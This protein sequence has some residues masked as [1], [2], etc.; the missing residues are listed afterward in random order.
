MSCLNEIIIVRHRSWKPAHRPFGV[1]CLRISP[2][3]SWFW[4]SALA[5]IW[6]SL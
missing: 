5:Q 4:N 3:T 6:R 1:Y 2:R